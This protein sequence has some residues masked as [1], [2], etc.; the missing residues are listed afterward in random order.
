MKPF[1]KDSPSISET[2]AKNRKKLSRKAKRIISIS[3]ILSLLAAFCISIVVSNYSL[4]ITTESFDSNKVDAPIK[5][6]LISDLHTRSFGDN[7]EDLITSIAAELP[8]VILLA[9]DIVSSDSTSDNDFKYLHNLVFELSKIAPVYFSIGNHERFNPYA[10]T[11]CSFVKSAGGT[12]LDGEFQDVLINGTPVRIG[13]I[14]Y[15]RFWDEESNSFLQEFTNAGNDTFT[16]LLCHNPEF[17]V[18]GI[19]NYNIDLI[20]SGHAHGGMVN[21]PLLGP[22]YAPEQ[23]WFPEYAAGLYETECGGHFAVTTGLG[24]SPE[25]M[26]RIFNRPEI[27]IIEIE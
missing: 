9:G 26:P 3:L 17:Y 18:W 10:E 25:Y 15:Y 23:G 8:D 13:A 6:A 20:A 16:L 19:K 27:M 5:L 21:L 12:V 24:S 4:K 14:S 22:L 1:D 11:I 2:T 7:N